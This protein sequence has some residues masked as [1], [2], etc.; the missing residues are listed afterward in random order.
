MAALAHV[1]EQLG[2][3][4]GGGDR[5]RQRD[6]EGHLAR[7]ER[8]FTRPTQAGGLGRRAEHVR[9]PAMRARG[10]SFASTLND[11]R[12]ERARVPEDGNGEEY[13]KLI[14]VELGERT[15]PLVLGG[16]ES[17]DGPHALDG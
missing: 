5:R 3:A 11:K 17:R 4:D 16:A 6:G 10:P 7:F 15:I 13:R 1:V 14:L 12:T 8:T 2:V 9:S